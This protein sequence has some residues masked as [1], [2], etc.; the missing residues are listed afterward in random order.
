MRIAPNAKFAC[1]GLTRCWLQDSTPAVL[2]L[3]PGMWASRT[4][5]LKMAEHWPAWLGSITMGTV[6]LGFLFSAR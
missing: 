2:Q 1:F 3:R 6:L 5:D 4:L